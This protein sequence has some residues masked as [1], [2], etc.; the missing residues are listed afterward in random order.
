MKIL[1]LLVTGGISL[2]V[3]QSN[4]LA[5]SEGGNSGATG[6]S[7]GN[8]GS[9][10]APS[11]ADEHGVGGKGTAGG[12]TSI[13]QSTNAPEFHPPATSASPK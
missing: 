9:S 11:G 8:S 12:G 6:G 5:Q 7:T 13:S 3:W 4:L 1:P 2:A 10:A